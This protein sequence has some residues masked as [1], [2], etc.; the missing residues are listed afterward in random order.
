M[1]TSHWI[2]AAV[3]AA[4]GVIAAGILLSAFFYPRERTPGWLM[5]LT[6]L[7]ALAVFIYILAKALRQGGGFRD[8]SPDRL[9]ADRPLCSGRFFHVAGLNLPPEVKCRVRCWPDRLTFSA[10]NQEFTIDNRK[11]RGVTR[12]TH[13][14]LRQ[15]YVSSAG[16]AIAGAAL[17]GPLGAVIGGGPRQKTVRD[18]TRYLIFA[19]GGNGEDTKY[20]VL[21]RSEWGSNGRSF[22]AAYKKQLKGSGTHVDL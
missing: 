16:G 10:M 21:R 14:Q 2:L 6:F 12:T 19:Y 4:L 17:F 15:Q 20:I 11:I 5:A 7:L 8:E 18:Y 13:K 9:D 1:K 22:A 3:G